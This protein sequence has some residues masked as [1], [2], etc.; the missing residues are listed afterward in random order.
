MLKNSGPEWTEFTQVY[1][2][3]F[4]NILIKVA[5]KE[6]DTDMIGSELE[7]LRKIFDLFNG[8]FLT[9]EELN[10][11]SQELIK[12]LL[13]SNERKDDTNNLAK[14]EIEE[15]EKELLEEEIVMEEEVQVAVS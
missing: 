8:K 5:I 11:F 13:K 12:V 7:A 15:E 4:I 3:N 1:T 9:A 6:Y 2:K 10:I 14:E